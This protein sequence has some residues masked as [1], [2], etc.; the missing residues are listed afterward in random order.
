MG[1]RHNQTISNSACHEQQNYSSAGF[2][3]NCIN[4][5]RALDIYSKNQSFKYLFSIFTLQ[6]VGLYL[7]PSKNQAFA[8]N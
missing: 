6:A 7:L 1:Y 8:A 5:P 4:P 2:K 3:T